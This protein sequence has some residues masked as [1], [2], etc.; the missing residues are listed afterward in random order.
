[1][2]RRKVRF[3][4]LTISKKNQMISKILD[5][6]KTVKKEGMRERLNS[7][8]YS[9]LGIDGLMFSRLQRLAEAGKLEEGVTE[10]EDYYENR[11]RDVPRLNISLRMR[12]GP[13]NRAYYFIAGLARRLC[14]ES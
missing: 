1:M 5:Y 10:L 13:G 7:L 14:L 12:I 8:W 9:Y 11:L 2:T 3:N 6:S 4:E